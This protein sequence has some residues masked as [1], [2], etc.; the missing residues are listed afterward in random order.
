MR[1]AAKATTPAVRPLRGRATDALVVA[2]ILVS[3]RS[4]PA[5]CGIEARVFRALVAKLG[6]PCTRVGKRLLVRAT[7]LAE[8]IGRPQDIGVDVQSVERRAEPTRSEI[9]ARVA[10]GG[11][12]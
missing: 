11:R 4:A 1:S 12:R 6:I 10:S 5:I 8:A 2:P 9:L 3:D 7:D